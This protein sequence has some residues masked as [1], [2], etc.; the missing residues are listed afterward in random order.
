MARASVP[1]L[2]L[3]LVPVLVGGLAGCQKEISTAFPEGLEPLGENTASWPTST[4]S[5][6]LS[7]VA[8]R[9][10]D[11]AWA[12]GRGY[13][14]ADLETVYAAL[15]TA[16]ACVDRREVADWEVSWDTEP[17]YDVSF[18]ITSYIEDIIDF[19]YDTAWRHGP[20]AD[21]EE[22]VITT[23]GSRW[24][25]TELR[26]GLETIK[27]MRGSVQLTEVEAGVTGFD[28]IEELDSLQPNNDADIATTFITDRY[29]D[30]LALSAGEALPE[31]ADEED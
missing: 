22:G 27:L 9:G 17:E 21:D 16:E 11:Y 29:A 2:V 14:Q 3:S 6:E 10:E 4:D 24:Q 7:V 26:A 1:R 20:T 23:Y 18:E 13:I 12:H 15:T 8:E 30:V 19:D 25:L 31:L 5:T 28:I